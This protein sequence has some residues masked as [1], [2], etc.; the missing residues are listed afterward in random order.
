M[1]SQWKRLR[2]CHVALKKVVGQI[3]PYTKFVCHSRQWCYYYCDR[4]RSVSGIQSWEFSLERRRTQRPVWLCWLE[5]HETM[6]LTFPRFLQRQ[7]LSKFARNALDPRT[8]ESTIAK[9]GFHSNKVLSSTRWGWKGIVCSFLKVK[10]SIQNIAINLTN[11]SE[12]TAR[13]GEPKRCKTALHR[14]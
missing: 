8:I 3:I 4:P 2:R 9:S 1:D 6:K 5:I 7:F 11:R 10:P 12:K 13:I 14:L